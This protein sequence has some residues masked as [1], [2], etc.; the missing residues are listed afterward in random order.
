MIF[1]AFV[2]SVHLCKSVRNRTHPL[3][4]MTHKQLAGEFY[5]SQSAQSSR[6]FL[7]H[8]FEP[9]EGLRHTEFTERCC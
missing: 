4:E 6:S 5:L 8:C 1:L 3:D 2:C 7:A 9:T